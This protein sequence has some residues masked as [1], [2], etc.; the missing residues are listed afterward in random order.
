MKKT[1][2]VLLVFMLITPFSACS[3]GIQNETQTKAPITELSTKDTEGKTLPKTDPDEEDSVLPE[4]TSINEET[5]TTNTASSNPETEVIEWNDSLEYAEYS[6]IHS[7]SVKLYKANNNRK[8]TVI[9]VNAGHGTKGGES[10]RTKC[11]PDGSAKVTGGSTKKGAITAAAVSSGM[12]FKNG[13]EEAKANLSLAKLVKEKLLKN[14]Y[15]VL[16]IREEDDV[17]LDNIARTVLANN[18]A[19]AHIA[20][21]YDSTESDKGLFYMGVPEVSSYRNMEPVKS[22]WKKHEAFGK[23]IVQGAKNNNVKIY[24]SGRMPIDL[25]QTSYSTIPSIDVEVG[26]RVSDT[27]EKTQS[28][29]ADGIIEGINIFFEN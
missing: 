7:S 14:G 27:G 20:L 12:T 2:V 5:K 19:D 28:N 10:V 23:A 4:S 6:K 22:N 13:M 8:N 1:F 9:C 26:D 25:T 3:R 29:I 15:D 16:M 11:H 24:S 17:Q 21:H 18:Y